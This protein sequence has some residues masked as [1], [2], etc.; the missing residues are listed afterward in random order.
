MRAG[1]GIA[2]AALLVAGGLW[3]AGVGQGGRVQRVVCAGATELT[4]SHL[5]YWLQHELPQEMVD[6]DTATLR[7]ELLNRFPL[8]DAVVERRWPATVQITVTER[9][10]Y[11]TLIDDADGQVAVL[12][13][14]GLLASLRHD[15]GV[16][17]WDRP[18]IRG[19]ALPIDAYETNDCI[20]R[21][22]SFMAW[23]DMT[24][25]GWLD[26]LSEILVDQDAVSVVTASGM[27]IAFGTAPFAP[28]LEALKYGWSLA[29]AR[30]LDVAGIVLS[31][32]G[33]VIFETHIGGTAHG[34]DRTHSA[35]RRNDEA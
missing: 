17:L 9:K 20:Q 19:C 10:P 28:K 29:Q 12:T 2:V 6:V 16:A 11:A 5:Y 3:A 14:D 35:E 21:G 30:Q 8:R 1:A 33:Q 27:R 4:E 24:E 34:G 18:L 23:L 25:G 22:V 7:R 32:Q 26:D 31:S 13:R 15:Q